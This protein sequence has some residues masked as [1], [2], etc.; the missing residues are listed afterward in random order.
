MMTVFACSAPL[1][2]DEVDSLPPAALASGDVLLVAA[3][4]TLG[5]GDTAVKNRF[6]GMGY[7]VTVKAAASSVSGDATGKALVAISSTVTSSDVAA[8]FRTVSVPT[9]TWENAL[10]DDMGM[11]STA[12]GNFGTSTAQTSVV[13]ATN[14]HP[15]AAGLSG[16]IAVSTA[17]SPLSWG[18]PNANAATIATV[19]GDA[20]QAVIFGYDSGAAMP[21]LTAP[22]RRVGFFL[23]D[24]T[25]STLTS[26]GWKLFDAAVA[27]ATNT[28]VAPTV[29]VAATDSDAGEPSNPGVFTITRTGSTTS[30]LAVSYTVGGTATSGSDYTALGTSVTIPAGAASATVTVTPIDDTVSEGS[31]TVTLTLASNSAYT[32]GSPSTATVTITDNDTTAPQILLV[33]GSTTLGAGDT[34]AQNRLTSLGYAVTAKAASSAVTADATGKALVVVSSTVTSSTVA[35]KYRDVKVPVLAWESA[36]LDDMGMTGTAS[37]AF[38]TTP[39]S[40]AAISAPNHPLAAGLSGTV[41][42]TN[43]GDTLSWGQPNDNAFKVAMIPGSSTNA[44]IFAYE[45]GAA[46]PGLTAPARRVGFFLG[47]ATAS[48]LTAAGWSLFDAAVKWA[49]APFPAA[50]TTERALILV[51]ERLSSKLGTRIADYQTLAA[52]KRGFGIA[53]HVISGIDEWRYDLVKSYI[54]TQRAGATNLEGV[55]FVGNIKIPSFFQSRTDTANTRLAPR[56]YED[57]DGVFEKHLTVGSTLP[58]CPIPWVETYNCF[59]STFTVPAHDFDFIGRGPAP[60]PEIWTSYMP[61]GGVGSDTYDDFATQLKP[62]LDKVIKYYQ[63]QLVGNG[64][65]YY[66]STNLGEQAD[67]VWTAFGKSKMNIWGKPG[68]NGEKGDACTSSGTNLCY[69]RWP[70]ETYPDVTT[71]LNTVLAGEAD[72]GDVWQDSSILVSHMSNVVYDVVEQNTHSNEIFEIA[73]ADQVRTM[74]KAGLFVALAGCGVGGFTQPGSPSYSDAVT[75]AYGNVMLS[76]LYGSSQALAASG[77]PFW[78]GHDAF[79]PTMYQYLKS[80]PG[81]YL[82]RAHLERNKAEFQ[83]STSD[84]ELREFGMEMLAGDPFMTLSP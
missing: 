5:T 4:T 39:G 73:Y 63:G 70:V 52:Q 79:Y 67:K 43:A 59:A 32:I 19:P 83:R 64:Q 58:I 84:G 38:G 26:D 55:L 81:S 25:A 78:R 41:T 54:Q 47:D 50:V 57:L 36:I 45:P 11:V 51:D 14:S 22:A 17:S 46:M 74:T 35:A 48:N 23:G 68:P 49:A 15:M 24:T 60:D 62:Y 13:I 69:A 82:G 65:Y 61:V 76:Y 8:K 10:L 77:D 66:V 33:V 3:S 34:A 80:T 18:K 21:G 31:E 53:L 29:T 1:G 7:T 2:R 44:S 71:Y 37:T 9:L 28:V 27:W 16:T 75:E 72:L 56:Y 42:L 40:T 30:A 6:T 20:T 12:A